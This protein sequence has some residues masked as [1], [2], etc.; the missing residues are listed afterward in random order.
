MAKTF[1]V[2]GLANRVKRVLKTRVSIES[3]VFKTRDAINIY[4]FKTGQLTIL[5]DTLCYLARGFYAAIAITNIG[6]H[7]YAVRYKNLVSEEDQSQPL[8]EIFAAEELKP[9]PPKVSATGFSLYDAVDAYDN[10]GWWVGTISRKRGSDH[11]YVFFNTY[12][13]EILYPLSRLRPYL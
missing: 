8:I 7:S 5:L 4:C 3:R 12:G 13:V 6:N 2:S 1:H 11:Y 9:M 10:D